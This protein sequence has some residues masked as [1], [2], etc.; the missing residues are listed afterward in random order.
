MASCVL[1]SLTTQQ[2]HN[3]DWDYLHYLTNSSK[4]QATLAWP[5][6]DLKSS[7]SLSVHQ[8]VLSLFNLKILAIFF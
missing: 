7:S 4:Q 1:K 3:K 2:F 8:N 6:P 5:N